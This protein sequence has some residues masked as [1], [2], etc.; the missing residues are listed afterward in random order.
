M[1]N[2]TL[3]VRNFNPARISLRPER[4]R[5]RQSRPGAG[6]QGRQ[7]AALHAAPVLGIGE[8]D[9]VLRARDEGDRKAAASS[10][11]ASS[12]APASVARCSASRVAKRKPCGVWARNRSFARHGPGDPPGG[13]AL[14]RIGHRHRRDRA[15]GLGQGRDQGR[16][17]A[18]RNQRPGGVMN[19]HQVRCVGASASSPSARARSP[20]GWRVAAPPDTRSA[21]DRG[22]RARTSSAAGSPARHGQ[23]ACGVER[24]RGPAHDRGGRRGENC[25]GVP[26]RTGCSDRRPPADR[27][28]PRWQSTI[29]ALR[30]F[31][32]KRIA[33]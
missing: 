12:V 8:L 20:R 16:D 3:L 21:G 10:S 14:Q 7:Q 18:G 28:D 5:G 27:G 26:R 1:P 17:G 24:I 25:L 29:H 22:R 32:L 15:L 23:S 9:V 4:R 19:Q 6:Q 31:R 30:R 33:L 2:K 11:A 13:G